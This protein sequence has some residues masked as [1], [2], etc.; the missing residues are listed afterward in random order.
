MSLESDG[1]KIDWAEAM[2]NFKTP[3]LDDFELSEKAT[4]IFKI[5]EMKHRGYIHVWDEHEV[6]V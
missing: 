2:R 4:K 6:K 5:V 3:M 1:L